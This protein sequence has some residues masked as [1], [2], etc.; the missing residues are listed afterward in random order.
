MQPLEIDTRW[1]SLLVRFIVCS[2][3]VYSA[4]GAGALPHFGPSGC[5]A[6]VHRPFVP[7]FQSRLDLLFPPNFSL[8][9]FS[10]LPFSAIS[11]PLVTRLCASIFP[12]ECLVPLFKPQIITLV[13]RFSF[14]PP[15]HFSQTPC[16]CSRS[17][18]SSTNGVRSFSLFA[19]SRF[20][21]PLSLISALMP[22]LVWL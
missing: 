12:T 21:I 9:A 7:S 14:L 20:E 3:R 17:C 18:S 5:G 1:P 22:S 2:S 19:S 11:F 10:S 13:L 8:L 15:G 16:V 6:P 4:R